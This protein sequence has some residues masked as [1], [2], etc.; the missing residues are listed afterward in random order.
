MCYFSESTGDGFLAHEI[1]REIVVGKIEKLRKSD[2]FYGTGT[3]A[4]L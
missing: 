4:L 2:Y 3:T 1:G